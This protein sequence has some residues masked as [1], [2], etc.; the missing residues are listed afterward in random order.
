VN[1]RWAQAWRVEPPACGERAGVVPGGRTS[2]R[3][4]PRAFGSTLR[5]VSGGGCSARSAPR[6]AWRHPAIGAV[7][8]PD[9]AAV[10]P[11][12]I[13]TDAVSTGWVSSVDNDPSTP[14]GR[15]FRGPVVTRPPQCVP[16][17]AGRQGS[18]LVEPQLPP[19]TGPVP[20]RHPVAP[21][22]TVRHVVVAVRDHRYVLAH[23]HHGVVLQ[24]GP[25]RASDL[26]YT[27]WSRTVGPTF[28]GRV[29]D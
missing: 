27:P 18:V 3:P 20:E 8:P 1:S 28:H 2:A 25:G 24:R 17:V 10:L 12:S 23:E 26:T 4:A 7:A 16:D 13:S 15:A 19:S 9:S 6:G 14:R 21:P 29:V 11:A 22:W 5:V